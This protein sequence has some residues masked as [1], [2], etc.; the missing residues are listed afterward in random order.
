VAESSR[1]SRM[2]GRAAA[3]P[4]SAETL[5]GAQGSFFSELINQDTTKIGP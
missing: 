3:G 2:Q 5:D 1:L 4:E